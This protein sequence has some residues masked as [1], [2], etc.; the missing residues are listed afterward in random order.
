MGMFEIALSNN[1]KKDH[2]GAIKRANTYP[3]IA[4]PS[5]KGGLLHSIRRYSMKGES[6]DHGGILRHSSFVLPT[7]DDDSSVVK[8]SKTSRRKLYIRRCAQAAAVL[9]CLSG[10]VASVIFF[11]ESDSDPSSLITGFSTTVSSVLENLFG[12]LSGQEEEETERDDL[13]LGEKRVMTE[14]LSEMM[15]PHDPPVMDINHDHDHFFI[16]TFRNHQKLSQRINK[17]PMR[18]R[19]MVQG[20]N[21]DMMTEKTD[22]RHYYLDQVAPVRIQQFRDNQRLTLRGGG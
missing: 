20:E 6:Q 17:D 9:V 18:Q 15:I 21:R 16:Q 22:V 5:T 12:S 11:E 1:L 2:K 14:Q 8:K 7:S 13:E 10:L 19:M 4:K 3:D